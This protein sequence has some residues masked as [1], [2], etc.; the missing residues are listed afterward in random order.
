MQA[1]QTQGFE[2]AISFCQEKAYPVTAAFADSVSLRRTALRHRNPANEPD[3]LEREV[4]ALIQSKMDA[5]LEPTPLVVRTTGE[6]HYFKAIILQ[7]MCVN[8]HGIPNKEIQPSTMSRIN[9]LYPQDQATGFKPGD[10]RGVW[11]IVFLERSEK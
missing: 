9:A 3:S 5:A 1:I 7:P 11:H 4:L 10:L 8:C 2:G 6:A